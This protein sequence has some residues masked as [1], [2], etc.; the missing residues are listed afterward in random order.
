M[1][2]VFFQLMTAWNVAFRFWPG[3]LAFFHGKRPAKK[4]KEIWKVICNIPQHTDATNGERGGRKNSIHFKRVRERNN[5]KILNLATSWVLIEF[6]LSKK[7]NG[8]FFD[9]EKF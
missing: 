7:D 5:K 8:K 4:R 1:V 6:A 2:S 9:G 3:Q